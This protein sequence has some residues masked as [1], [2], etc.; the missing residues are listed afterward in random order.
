[1]T[2][3]LTKILKDSQSAVVLFTALAFFCS[4]QRWPVAV[5][6]F[7][8][9]QLVLMLLAR[10]GHGRGRANEPMRFYGRAAAAPPETMLHARCP[11]LRRAHLHLVP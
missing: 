11:P 7:L 8:G 10:F 3:P 5:A 9:L 6:V 2:S 1:M 4:N